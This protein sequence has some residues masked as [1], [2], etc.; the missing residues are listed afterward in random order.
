MKIGE[1]AM[2]KSSLLSGRSG[3]RKGKII[4]TMMQ[5]VTSQKQRTDANHYLEALKG[6]QESVWGGTEFWPDKWMLHHDNCTWCIRSSKVP[7]KEIHDKNGTSTLFTR[8]SPLWILAIFKI[9][10]FLDKQSF[11]DIHVIKEQVIIEN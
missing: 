11:V 4:Y 6:L 2:K 8:L 7:G 3:W 9:K 5:E 10:K 1:H